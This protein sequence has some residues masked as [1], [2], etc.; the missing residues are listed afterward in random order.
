VEILCAGS[1]EADEGE[2]WEAEISIED[3]LW[4]LLLL[5]LKGPPR[6]EVIQM[7]VQSH[8]YKYCEY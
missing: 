6:D 5:A 3:N 8:L 7:S 1:R 4:I 2:S